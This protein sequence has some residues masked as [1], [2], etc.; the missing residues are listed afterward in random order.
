MQIQN[1]FCVGRNYR[2]HAAELGNDVP[3]SPMIFSKPTH[4]LVEAAGQVIPLPG[5][6]GEV[7]F[8]AEL[9]LHIARPFEPGVTLEQMVDK[10]ALGI[11]WTLRDVQSNLKKKGHPWL[12]AKGFPNSAVVTPFRPFPGVE[13]LEQTPFSLL[14]NGETVQS[15]KLSEA[16][17]DAMTILSFISENFGLKAGDIVYTGTPAG[18]GPARDNDRFELRWG[19]ENWGSFTVQLR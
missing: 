10:I 13:A 7:H 19:E 6:K 18:V 1:I 2:L 11:D 15:G 5:T 8:E 17:F 14:K 4:S 9:V 12:L 3:T 16:I